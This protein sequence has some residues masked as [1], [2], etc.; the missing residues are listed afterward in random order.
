M[1]GR[2]ASRRSPVPLCLG[3]CLVSTHAQ[4][5]QARTT[6]HRQL[7]LPRLTD[8]FL[9][10]GRW[11]DDPQLY[12]REFGEGATPVIM[13]HGG[14]GAEH[15]GLVDAVKALGDRYRF[16]FYDQRGSLRSPSPDSLITFDRHIDDLERLRQE[17]RLDKLTIVGHSMGAV[18]ASAYASKYPNRVE[19][20]ILLS[21][22]P[23]KNPIPEGD[24]A[25]RHEGYQASQ[26][27]LNRPEVAQELARYS[28]TRT[29]SPCLLERRRPKFRIN[30]ARRMLYDVR[31][32]RLLTGGRALYKGHV[33]QLTSKTYP[34][35]GWDSS[36]SSSAKPIPSASAS[37]TT[38][39]WISAIRS[40]GSG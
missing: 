18:L 1:N 38:I 40:S 6:A 24:N 35:S 39:S 2:C 21:P 9:S 33:D 26:V 7:S 36:R 12:V 10:T 14:W 25:A 11:D 27:F 20:L 34:S 16:I 19:Q 28:L 3:V 17:L 31:N 22:A 5:P 8:W 30:F 37:A 15:S 13:L 29:D 4:V 23:L 32:W